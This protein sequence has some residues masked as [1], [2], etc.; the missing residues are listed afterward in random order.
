MIRK[1]F[2]KDIIK[3]SVSNGIRLLASFLTGILLPILFSVENYGFYKLFILYTS[4]AGLLH[5]GFIDGIYLKYGGNNYSELDKKEFSNYTKMLIIIEVLMSLI[6]LILVLNL[7]EGDRQI[8]FIYWSI[9]L[10]FINI[11]SYYQIISQITS[12]FNEFA[13]RNIIYAIF[14]SISIC[15]IYIFKIDD[16]KF[17]LLCI[18]I[19]NLIMLIW[20]SITYK[21]ISPKLLN[22]FKFDFGSFKKIFKLGFPLIIANFISN[23]ILS[24]SRQF[25]DWFYDIETFAH[26]SYAFSLMSLTNVFI[27]AVGTVIYPT[28]KKIKLSKLMNYYNKSISIILALVF[29]AIALFFPLSIFIVRFLPSYSN[30]LPILRIIFPSLSMS[31]S[32][33][34]V[35]LNYFK[36]LQNNKDYLKS[37]FATLII[38]LILNFLAFYFFGTLESIA[39]SSVI[40]YFIWYIIT[41]IFFLKRVKMKESLKNL[42]Y[43]IINTI[44]FYLI[45]IFFNDILGMILYI[46]FTTIIIIFFFRKIITNQIFKLRKSN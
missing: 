1:K 45:S 24:F 11:V 3:V 10:L 32:I 19:I 20:Y 8:V 36:S 41:E 6:S 9:N 34:I 25:V 2:L 27:I 37:G 29:L 39:I 26:F 43:I 17:L 22:C 18:V 35:K 15:L 21:D 23:L 40:A 44:L 31:A 4:F 28:L 38:S 5:F 12:R 33:Q 13:L 7:M 42:I 14:I 30:S 16:Y 46:L